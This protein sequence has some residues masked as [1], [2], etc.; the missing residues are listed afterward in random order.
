MFTQSGLILRFYFS[1]KWKEVN[2]GI[3]WASYALH[4]W[5]FSVSPSS[6]MALKPARDTELS[7]LKRIQSPLVVDNIGAGRVVL[8]YF[9]MSGSVLARPVSNLK[10]IWLGNATKMAML[11]DQMLFTS[12]VI[13][14][15][16]T[17]HTSTKSKRQP[18][19]VSRSMWVKLSATC[20][21]RGILMI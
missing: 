8:Q 2:F 20:S 3:Q 10:E 19:W 14:I 21:L 17:N 4:K 1:E 18:L 12:P 13:N 11:K 6:Y 16:Y 5:G 15:N 9:P 7:D